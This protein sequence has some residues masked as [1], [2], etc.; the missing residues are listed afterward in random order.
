MGRGAP[1]VRAY[2]Y[3][4]IKVTHERRKKGLEQMVVGQEYTQGQCFLSHDDMK[5]L[6]RLGYI[7]IS[8][9]YTS[10]AGTLIFVRVEE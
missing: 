3:S 5:A 6:R 7:R 2:K 9:R 4:E 10:K 8:K 1:W